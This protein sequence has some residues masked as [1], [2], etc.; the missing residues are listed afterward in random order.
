[1]EVKAAR[2][3]R[4][5]Q[6]EVVLSQ[7]WL[8]AEGAGSATGSKRVLWSGRASEGQIIRVQVAL[9]AARADAPARAAQMRLVDASGSRG[10]SS[11]GS[12][13]ILIPAVGANA[14]N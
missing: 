13:D 2:A 6:I 8:F 4:R 14:K 3:I 9:K 12:A 7:G 1:M 10:A 5:A 11:L